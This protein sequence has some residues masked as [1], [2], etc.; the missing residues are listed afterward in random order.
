MLLVAISFM[1]EGFES[2]R[3][4]KKEIGTHNGVPIVK[5]GEFAAHKAFVESVTRVLC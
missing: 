5:V 1:R 4:T 3:S 2:V